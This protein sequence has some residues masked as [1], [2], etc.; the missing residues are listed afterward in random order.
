M[1][2]V[3][4]YYY[5]KP[6]IPRRMQI[7]LR[8]VLAAHKRESTKDVWPICPE[9]KKKPVNWKGW[10]DGKRFAFI[11][12][13]DVDTEK[14]LLNCSSLMNVERQLN[15]RS[16]FNFVPEDYFTPYDQRRSLTESGFE[17]GVHG[18]KHDGKLFKDPAGFNRRATSINHYLKEWDAVGF[19]SPSMLRNLSLMAEL[20]IEHGCS[21]FDTD[22]FEPQSEGVG[23]I[24]PFYARNQSKTKSYVE[25]PY[26][27][28]Q[29]HC[30]FI[31]LRERDIRIWK[32]KLDWIVENGGMALLNTHPDYMNFD[33]TRCSLE[34]YPISYYTDFLEYVRS[35]YSGQCWHALPRELAEF[36]RK[37]M[38][39]KETFFQQRIAQ[40]NENN[41]LAPLR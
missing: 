38:P 22:P 26:T 12:Q 34:E 13:H 16:S 27:L 1:K 24:F 9:S 37:S 36:W 21:T 32:E 18:L 11:L 8:R 4:L 10:P 41:N 33:G 14:G 23:M 20:D 19:T 25:H 3:Y 39:E 15:F 28:P 30:L 2:L 7:L 35:Q 40:S 5:F 29:D 31:I 17:V 6:V